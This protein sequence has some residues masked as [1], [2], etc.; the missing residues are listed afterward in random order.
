MMLPKILSTLERVF[1]KFNPKTN[2]VFDVLV[3]F[4]VAK[5]IETRDLQIDDS[6]RPHL[7]DDQSDKS[8][9]TTSEK[10]SENKP[11]SFRE[12]IVVWEMLL[13]TV[14]EAFC[15]RGFVITNDYHIIVALAGVFTALRINSLIENIRKRDDCGMR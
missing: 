12:R 14:C 5:A 13:A 4:R 7:T 1:D 11:Q 6:N 3:P 10:L 8:Q 2:E 15:L 9:E